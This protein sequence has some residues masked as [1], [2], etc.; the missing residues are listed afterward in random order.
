MHWNEGAR[1]TIR[2]A[3]EAETGWRKNS[4]STLDE[5]EHSKW[6]HLCHHLSEDREWERA[7]EKKNFIPMSSYYYSL[8]LFTTTRC[9]GWS[10]FAVKRERIHLSILHIHNSICL[11][12]VGTYRHFS[13][14]HGRDRKTKLMQKYVCEPVYVCLNEEMERQETARCR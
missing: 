4:S 13:H 14:P 6:R 3:K 1:D 10:I 9:S 12:A 7:R 11:K 8:L 5:F 2:Y